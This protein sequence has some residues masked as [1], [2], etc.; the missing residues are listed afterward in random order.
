M[1]STSASDYNE[2]YCKTDF[3]KKKNVVDSTAERKNKQKEGIFLMWGKLEKKI[4]SERIFFCVG[5][6]AGRSMEVVEC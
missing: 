2:R 1:H 5:G 4:I 3:P 6:W